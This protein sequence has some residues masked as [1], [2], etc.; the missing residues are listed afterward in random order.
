MPWPAT[1]VVASPGVGRYNVLQC[2]QRYTSAFGPQAFSTSPH[3][4]STASVMYDQSFKWPPQNL[5]FSFFS[6]QARCPA[7]LI[8]TL[9]CGSCGAFCAP[10]VCVPEVVTSLVAKDVP[11][12]RAAQTPPDSALRGHCNRKCGR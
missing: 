1:L 4:R 5:P 6:L 8:L 7:F 9:W 3:S 12:I 11:L 10:A 2:S